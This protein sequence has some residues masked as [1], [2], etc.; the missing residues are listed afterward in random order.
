MTN[1]ITPMRFDWA[2]VVLGCGSLGGTAALLGS[3]PSSVG[4][5]SLIT[6]LSN[7]GAGWCAALVTKA[8]AWHA[9]AQEGASW[10]SC[11]IASSDTTWLLSSA[12]AD[13]ANLP[14]V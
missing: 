12:F 13:R 14:R 4:R 2:P 8:C 3:L 7:E 6:P 10:I 5:R 9:T 11:G 1:S